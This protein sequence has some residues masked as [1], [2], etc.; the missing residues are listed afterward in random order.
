M[1]LTIRKLSYALGAEISGVDFAKSTTDE[2]FAEIRHAFLEHCVL[3]IRG[4]RFTRDEFVAFSRHFGKLKDK[5]SR[6]APGY[7]EI[8]TLASKPQKHGQPADLSYNGNDWHSD[9][10]YTVA[11]TIISILKAIELPAVGG[12]TQFANMYLAYETL[13]DGMKKLLDGLYAV[14]MQEEKDLDHSSPERLEEDRRKKTAAHPLVKTHPDTGRKS[15][16]IGDKTMLVEGMTRDESRP[17][18][19]FLRAHCSRPQFIY[20]HRWQ[21]DDLLIWDQRCTN[22]IAL[23]DFDRMHELRAM[24]KTTVPGPVVGHHYVDNSGVRNIS[25]GFNYQTAAN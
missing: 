23:G 15:L 22:H 7:P 1:A 12:D 24:E 9:I 8:Q 2:V 25:H 5:Q 18:L 17:I 3:L 11:P 4:Q 16:Y 14:H 20:R 13:S 19:D 10:S 6:P 21:K